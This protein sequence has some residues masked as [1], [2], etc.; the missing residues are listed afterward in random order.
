[1]YSLFIFIIAVTSTIFVTSVIYS[2][3]SKPLDQRGKHDNK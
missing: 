3:C 1:M 2:A